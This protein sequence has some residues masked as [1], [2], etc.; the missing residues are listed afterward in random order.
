MRRLLI[1]CGRSVCK[2]KRGLIPSL[3][4]YINCGS[5]G[6]DLGDG[7]LRK[8]Y[9]GPIGT[10][11]SYFQ[12]TLLFQLLSP[13]LSL[14]FLLTL[15]NFKSLSHIVPSYQILLSSKIHKKLPISYVETSYHYNLPPSYLRDRKRLKSRRAKLGEILIS[16]RLAKPN[17]ILIRYLKN[18]QHNRNFWTTHLSFTDRADDL[19][20]NQFVYLFSFL[21]SIHTKNQAAIIVSKS[22]MSPSL[23][24][25]QKLLLLLPLYTLSSMLL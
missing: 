14:Q 12:S 16:S 7:E 6:S 1:S 11:L 25:Y 19:Q 13:R 15:C 2:N 24:H 5:Q 20:P 21:R 9:P 8:G 3:F 4:L 10:P 17:Y 18:G 23:L 22:L